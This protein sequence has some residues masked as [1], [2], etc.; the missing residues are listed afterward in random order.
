MTK[1]KSVNQ[2]DGSVWMFV[3]VNDTAEL[4]AHKTKLRYAVGSIAIAVLDDKIYALSSSGEW[5]EQNHI[6]VTIA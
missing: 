4:L 1:I 6:T 2:Y 5:I 3:A